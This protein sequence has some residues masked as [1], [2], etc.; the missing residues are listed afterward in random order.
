MRLKQ[1]KRIFFLLCF[2]I[3][4]TTS[5]FAQRSVADS[6][7]RVIGF[8]NDTNRINL[9]LKL[10]EAYLNYAPKLAVESAQ[11]AKVLASQLQNDNLEA[12]SL[13]ILGRVYFRIGNFKDALSFYD[14]AN[15]IFTRIGNTNKAA[16]ILNIMA[17]CYQAT[18][19]YNAALGKSFEAYQILEKQGDKGGMSASLITSGNVYRAMHDY[20]KA[21]IDY[22]KALILA[23]ESG[24]SDNEANSEM[25]LSNAFGD[26][27]KNDTAISY[28]KKAL[29]VFIKNHDRMGE[30]KVLNNIGTCLM[31]QG[32]YDEAIDYFLQAQN[33]QKEI[34]DNRGAAISLSNIGA[35]MYDKDDVDKAIDYFERA[36]ERAKIS[37]AADLEITMLENLAECYSSKGD[38]EK[39]LQIVNKK[40]VLKD[41][42]FNNNL[43]ESIAE[44]QAQYDVKKAESETRAQLKEKKLIT[45]ASAVGG[46]LLVVVVFFLWNRAV[47]RKK[48]NV[49]LNTQKELIELKNSALHE[50]N[51][52][53][54][55][56]NKDITDSIRYA[57]KIQEAILPEVEFT[58]TFGDSAFVLYRPK[59]IVSG[60][61]YWMAQTEEHLLFAAVDCTGHGV[62]GAFV[63]IVCSNLLHQSVK[64]HGFT[65]PDQILNDVNIRLSETLRQRQDESR[66]RD[67]MDIALCCVHKKTLLLTF[68]GAYNP[69]WVFRGDQLTELLP[70]KFPIG[71]FEE[72]ELRKFS[73]KEFQLVPGDRI[74]VFSDGFADQFGGALGKKYKRS[75]FVEFVKNIQSQ[76]IGVQG[77]L[78]NQEHLRWKGS[79]EQIDD[80]LVL[81]V[82]V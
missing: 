63:S 22:E 51:V 60:D 72:E 69:A 30:G 5:V 37:G 44:M 36:L 43:S 25:A 41:S 64:E 67:G 12:K 45:I 9:L 78:L 19:K 47:T 4:I 10:T 71:L 14:Q 57:R 66:V 54:E 16:K 76:P 33:I 49:K 31:D 24:I 73:C 48:V 52:E 55:S 27:G 13:N 74:Y 70:D 62:P 34:G 68:A 65:R 58:A 38:F 35:I 21:I 32:K 29:A 7:K 26:L 59:D 56:K 8:S 3:A 1:G 40:D 75:T 53:I 6:I 81:G 28:S 82:E 50:A 2:S 18:G 42:I 20:N 11:E 61:F 80:I 77:K 46:V 79:N 17:D 39:S 15:K 23:K